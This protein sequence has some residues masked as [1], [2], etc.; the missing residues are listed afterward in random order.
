MESKIKPL[1]DKGESKEHSKNES[2][3]HILSN[4]N[5]LSTSLGGGMKVNEHVMELRETVKIKIRQ[6]K[7]KADKLVDVLIALADKYQDILE[8]INKLL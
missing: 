6:N 1:N 5:G 4:E 8:E 7:M 3:N 2:S